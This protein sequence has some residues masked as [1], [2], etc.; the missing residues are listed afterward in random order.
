LKTANDE[1]RNQKELI[2]SLECDLLMVNSTIRPHPDVSFDLYS[3][4]FII[5]RVHRQ[6]MMMK[7]KQ[8]W[9]ND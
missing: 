1:I 3:V 4:L 7:Q 9:L 8:I 2:A 5:Y 6:M